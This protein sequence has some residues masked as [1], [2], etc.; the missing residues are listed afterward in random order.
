MGFS[1]DFQANAQSNGFRAEGVHDL[2][3][4]NFAP[5]IAQGLAQQQA[6]MQQQN[7]LQAQQGQLSQALQ[8]QAAGYGPSLAQM[9][10]QQA[11]G[12]NI[13]N[14]ASTIASQKGIN[15]GLGARLIAQNQAAMQQ[16]AAGQSGMTRLAEQQGAQNA[17]AGLYGQQQAGALQQAGLGGQLLGTAGGL[18]NAQNAG[19]MQNAFT[20]QQMNL[21]AQL[22][23]QQA[24]M[25]AQRINAGVAQQNNQMSNDILRGAISGAAGAGAMA[26]GMSGGGMVSS[27][28]PGYFGGA[29]VPG[30]SPRNDTVPAMLSP[31]EIVLPRSVTQDEDAEEKAAAFVHAIK[32]RK[33]KG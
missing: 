21:Q 9:Q 3:R 33:S 22:A 8:A 19:L 16:Q 5:G 27:C 31:G 4:S 6:A 12:Q 29:L 28:V 26:M 1:N 13:N 17:L 15:P 30:D 24:K 11:T 7:G 2:D 25:D 32:A 20:P 23:D 18:Q 10:L 14:A